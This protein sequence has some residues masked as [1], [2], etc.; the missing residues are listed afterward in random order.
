MKALAILL[1][2]GL[3]Q[4]RPGH[5]EAAPG[6][7]A[8]V[9]AQVYKD[10]M[11][12]Q[13]DFYQ[14]SM[15]HFQGVLSLVGF[16]IAAVSLF[17]GGVA[18]LVKRNVD[19]V[20]ARVQSLNAEI[21]RLRAKAKADADEAVRAHVSQFDEALADISQRRS[22]LESRLEKF[23]KL[24]A[25]VQ[26]TT[27]VARIAALNIELIHGIDQRKIVVAAD[28]SNTDDAHFAEIL[29]IWLYCLRPETKVPSQVRSVAIECLSK[30]PKTWAQLP[31]VIDLLA[32]AV[33]QN[34]ADLGRV[35]AKALA[36]L[37]EVSPLDAR[38]RG[39]LENYYKVLPEGDER[40]DLERF[41][42]EM[43]SVA[44]NHQ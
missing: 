27:A 44:M 40:S 25:E 43:N 37:L 29:P 16:C 30:K 8:A 36:G 39:C 19:N 11:D 34:L 7:A 10:A 13:D 3:A 22:E 28:L 9:D 17:V 26:R 15:S 4:A 14:A 23:R 33:D 12:R 35:A 24:E 2:A 18:F 21:E 20:E 32:R 5:A 6:P 41:L 42:G 31:E 1:A 38:C